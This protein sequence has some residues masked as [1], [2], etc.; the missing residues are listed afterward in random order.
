MP[1]I[2][3]QSSIE[4]DKAPNYATFLSDCFNATARS[5]TEIILHGVPTGTWGDT[6]GSNLFGY[7][8]AYHTILF[9]PFV[10]AAIQAEREGY[11]AFIIGTYIEPFLREIRSAVNIPVVSNFEATLLLGCSVGHRLGFLTLNHSL[12]RIM[13]TNLAA[14]ALGNRVASIRVVEPAFDEN[15]MSRA[16]DDPGPYIDRFRATARHAMVD[17]ADV[18]VP[19]EGIIAALAARHRLH[20]IDGTTVLDG[21]AVPIAYAEMM[22]HLRDAAGLRTSRGWYLSQ[23]P[24]AALEF[25]I[26]RM[27]GRR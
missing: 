4:F 22:I 14:H 16:L 8:L 13:E 3:Y 7:P 12:K 15:D 11:D 19:A 23:P 25:C 6:V 27:S 20:E 10:G 21:I 1:K 18:I 26:D 17:G 2:W 9:K 24:Q 5:G